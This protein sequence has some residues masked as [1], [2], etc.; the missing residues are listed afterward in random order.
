MKQISPR[1]RRRDERGSMA[2]ELVILA[3]ILLMFAMLVVAGGRHVG[4]QGDIDAAARDAVRAASQERSH[5]EAEQVA[6]QFVQGSLDAGTTCTSV[7]LSQPWEAGGTATIYLDC[8]VSYAG[9][10]L[11]GLPGSA[12]LDAESSAPLDRY[13]RYE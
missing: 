4:V 11:I 2:V 12:D 7:E 9:L 1:R 3:P 13:A 10:G 5:A 8:S 6:R